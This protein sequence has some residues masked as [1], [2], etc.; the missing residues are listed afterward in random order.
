MKKYAY[1]LIL[2]SVLWVTPCALMAQAASWI[3]NLSFGD[4]NSE[5]NHSLTAVSSE[6]IKG[7]M[8][9]PARILLPQEPLTWEGGK[10]SFMTKVDAQKQN[11][12]TVKFWG[13]DQDK[14]M[15][16][17]FIEG[18]QVG[19]RHLG[20][21]DLL[22]LGNGGIP[23]K[24]RFFY[25]TLPLP[26]T[27]T[28]GK[29][30]VN[31]EIRSSGEIWGYGE[32]FNKYQKNMTE[33][34]LGIYEAF[35]H[36][37]TAFEPRPEDLA[38]LKSPRQ[39]RRDT[40]NEEVIEQ[41]KLRVNKELARILATD[42]PLNQ[43]E[44][45]FLADAY[46]VNWT[47]AHQNPLVTNKIVT[48][49][50]DHYKKYL[51]NPELLTTDKAV[52]NPDW[53]VAGLFARCIRTQWDNLIP[54]LDQEFEDGVGQRISHR[55][56]W[57]TLMKA[58]LTYSTT[59]RRWYTNQTMIIDLFMY[60]CNKALAMLS[61]KEALPQSQTLG[62]LYESLALKPWLGK[63]T[64]KGQE[65][66]LGENYWQLTDKGLTKELGFVGYYG[67]VLDWMIDIYKSTSEGGKGD[68]KIKQQ[69]LKVMN[70]RSYFRYPEVDEDGYKAFRAETVVGWRDAGHYPA[71]VLYGDRGIAWDAS[72]LMTAATTLDSRAIGIAQ[73]MLEDNQ[74]FKMVQDKMKL[75]GI[76]VTKSLL[77]LPDEYE[78]IKAQPKSKLSLQMADESP[79]FVF[80]DEED[81]VVAIKNGKECLYVSLYWRARHGINNLAKVHYIKPTIDR[82]A[83]VYL[84]SSYTPSGM[85]YKRPN[86]VNLGFSSIRDFYPNLES[87]HTGEEL[88]IAKIPEGVP[89]KAGD[90]SIFAGKAD[91]YRLEYGN[92]LIAMNMTKDKTFDLAIP[93]GFQK[94]KELVSQSLVKQENSMKVKPRTT[95][96]LF[97]KQ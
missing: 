26:L 82:I 15:L 51:K 31:L 9:K 48:A 12:I 21:I 39:K 73:Q 19:Y 36:V 17:L 93:E 24:D 50:D 52:Y 20:D 23:F 33:K 85:T 32:T 35:V 10:V 37:N 18:K 34:S 14:T 65:K 25:V 57:A 2:L 44:A 53:L 74:F 49:I 56:A 42:K 4:E 45:V 30:Q 1:S 46:R 81:G 60:D 78:L 86:W 83:N 67:E 38:G 5:R 7:A 87:A 27:Y 64:G 91:F 72:P 54:I 59:H 61:P 92:Y 41:V 84:T 29:A 90:E 97:K 95:V 62:Y 3:D 80:A 13:S 68:E 28:K 75:P 89:F 47:L 76:R 6:K 66:P 96:V 88:P 58:S 94:A 8:G 16:M 43:Q 63:E 69:V 22:W 79:D 71:N 11:Y 40:P 70:A 55:K 77:Y